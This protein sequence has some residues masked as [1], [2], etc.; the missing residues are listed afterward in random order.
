[1][2]L[3]C[4]W[5]VEAATAAI[6]AAAASDPSAAAGP[7]TSAPDRNG[8]VGASVSGVGEQQGLKN[9]LELPADLKARI[10][11]ELKIHPPQVSMLCQV[12]C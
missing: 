7:S 10:T 1:M 6:A 8:A 3:D 4:P 5:V 12:A 2:L 11:K 9:P